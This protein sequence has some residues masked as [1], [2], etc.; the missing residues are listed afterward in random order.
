MRPRKALVYLQIADRYPRGSWRSGVNATVVN[1]TNNPPE[2]VAPGCIVVPV[3]VNVPASRW[4]RHE[5]A[6]TVEIPEY[7][8][9]VQ[10]EAG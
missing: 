4:A 9:T 10:A 2:T 5:D 8:D 6:V 3:F 7:D 1:A